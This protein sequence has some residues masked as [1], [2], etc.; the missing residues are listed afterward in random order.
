MELHSD[1]SIQLQWL[2][3]YT[4]L[5]RMEVHQSQTFQ[6][7]LVLLCKPTLCCVPVLF[8]SSGDAVVASIACC[9]YLQTT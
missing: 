4:V 3:Y 2:L 8:E 7:A 6:V 1:Y 9:S 5:T